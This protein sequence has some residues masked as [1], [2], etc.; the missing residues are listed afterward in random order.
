M[1]DR[2]TGALGDLGD[3]AAEIVTDFLVETR[4]NLDQV[5]RDLLDLGARSSAGAPADA[6]PSSAELL[7]RIFRTL[8]TIKGTCRFL[9]FDHL[10]ALAHAGE[11]LLTRLR[12]RQLA[13]TPRTLTALLRLV[14]CGGSL[15]RVIERTGADADP[16]VPVGPVIAALDGCPDEAHPG[17]GAD[18]AAAPAGTTAE[19]GHRGRTDTSVRVDLKLLDA[20]VQLVG[21]LV[22]TRNRIRQLVDPVTDPE[23]GQVTQRL[24]LVVS[25]LQKGVL[26]TRMQP[27]GD[28]WVRLP[29]VVRDLA[30]QLDRQVSLRLSGHETE[31][32][33]S[34][35]E[36]LRDPILHLVRNAVDHGIEPPGE[37]AEAGKPP[38]GT[39]TVRAFQEDGQ[40]V[41]EVADDGRGLDA[42]CILAAALRRGLISPAQVT[43]LAPE[44]VFDLVFRS[45]LSTSEEITTVSGRG[46]GMD[47]VRTNVERV[48]GTVEMAGSQGTGTTCRIRLPLAVAPVPALPVG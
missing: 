33:R 25:E 20:L 35:L 37:R 30:A 38:E 43:A 27:I 8:H 10:E 18:G 47:V 42:A 24:D 26:Q 29:H 12:D 19:D 15:L 9:A 3:D 6:G 11:D 17:A 16:S 44:D 41:V 32:D 7:S 36:A 45:G 34:L 21:E 4:E 39:L 2:E 1:D 23:L 31:L 48:G 14:D 5:H 22:L 13:A 28:A 46:V 40:V